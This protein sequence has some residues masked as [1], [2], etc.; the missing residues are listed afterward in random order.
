MHSVLI[1]HAAELDTADIEQITKHSPRDWLQQL[2]KTTMND[3]RVQAASLWYACLIMDKP[4]STENAANGDLISF[5]VMTQDNEFNPAICDV[6]N[7][8]PLHTA[9]IMYVFTRAEYQWQ[10]FAKMLFEKLADFA[11]NELP[12]IKELVRTTGTE[13]NKQIYLHHGAALHTPQHLNTFL[14]KEGIDQDYFF[15]RK[16]R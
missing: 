14:I 8:N 10:W 15:S 13:K 1:K 4:E 9:T 3:V 5:G 7:K 11:K 2:W 12:W 6:L 16:V